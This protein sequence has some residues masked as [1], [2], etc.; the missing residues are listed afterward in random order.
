MFE[1]HGGWKLQACFLE[2]DGGEDTVIDVWEI[3][4]PESVQKN[5]ASAPND[6]AFQEL[7]PSFG[8]CVETET[9]HVMNRQPVAM[10]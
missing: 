2:D 6:L 10:G 5:L 9:L 1:K 7:R 3:P 8:E 4:N